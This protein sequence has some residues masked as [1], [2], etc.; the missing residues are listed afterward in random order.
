MDLGSHTSD[1]FCI[2]FFGLCSY[3]DVTPYNVSFP[4]PKPSGSRPEPSGQTP[5]QVV[6]FSDIHVDQFYVTGSSTNC[7]KPICCRD[8]TT[9]D[10]P[11]NNNYPAGPN[12]DHNCDAPVSLE[13]SMYAA[14]RQFAP[15]ATFSLFT[16]D[17][18][19]HA[20]WNTTQAQNT[21]DINDA[22]TRM[23]S[24]GFPVFGTV[25]NHEM[26]P[27]NA[28]PPIA[29]GN[30]AQWVYN[31]L[32]SDWASWIGGSSTTEE[33]EVGAYSTTFGST[34]LR[35]ISINTNMYYVQNY[36][37]YED[38][39]ETDPS[40]QLAWLVNEL[41][42]AETA[43]ERVYIIGHTPMGLSDAFHDGSNYFDQIVNRYS[44]TIAA[45]FFGKS[46]RWIHINLLTV[47]RR[48]HSL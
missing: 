36:W 19:D 3:P 38:P 40:G 28:F 1:L 35:I 29:V 18:V 9:A 15:N 43:G 2:T 12:G 5:L 4:S 20:V 14:I 23:G 24:L 10:S 17:I 6:Q 30:E 27:T 48:P 46:N 45:L 33:N 41:Q 22:Y 31:L 34:T 13:E 21:I 37:L 11:G 47:M 26:S 39:M 44:N 7:S 8:Y 25:G 16:G 32:F 42:E